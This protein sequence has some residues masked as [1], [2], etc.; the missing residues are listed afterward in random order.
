MSAKRRKLEN[1]HE[2]ITQDITPSPSYDSIK[3]GDVHRH[4]L[5][6]AEKPD[7]LAMGSTSR[8]QHVSR[9]HLIQTQVDRFLDVY[10]EY[11]AE[12][13]VYEKLKQEQKENEPLGVFWRRMD[14][15]PEWVLV[16][17]NLINLSIKA[18]EALVEIPDA[19]TQVDLYNYYYGVNPDVPLLARVKNEKAWYLSKSDFKKPPVTLTILD[20]LEK[21]K[22]WPK[23]FDKA[24]PQ[25]LR[26]IYRYMK[27]QELFLDD[28]FQHFAPKLLNFIKPEKPL[29]EEE[30]TYLQ[31]KYPSYFEHTNGS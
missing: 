21:N 20:G 12:H 29:S 28:L 31:N 26:A 19:K 27:F 17:K 9:K 10:N 6:F 14:K 5:K 24:S 3:S 8:S 1:K 23:F 15:V 13:N 25:L 22:N 2:D 18:A 30:L 4:V 16:K 7:S 11:V